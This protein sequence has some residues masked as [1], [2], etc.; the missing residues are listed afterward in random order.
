MNRDQIHVKKKYIIIIFI[1][2]T[3]LV[4]IC[5]NGFLIYTINNPPFSYWKAGIIF[6]LV[7]TANAFMVKAIVKKSK[8]E[9]IREMEKR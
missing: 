1:A 2:M 5:F 9:S 7:F 8:D 4:G 3:L 6:I